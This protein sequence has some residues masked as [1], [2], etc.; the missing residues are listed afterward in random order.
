MRHTHDYEKSISEIE[1]IKCSDDYSNSVFETYKQTLNR[2]YNYN[3][4]GFLITATAICAMGAYMYISGPKNLIKG[5][6]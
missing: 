5:R 1:E 2:S 3:L 6:A 4:A